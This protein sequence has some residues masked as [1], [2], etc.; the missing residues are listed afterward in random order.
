MSKQ[1]PEIA[2]Y[3]TTDGDRVKTGNPLTLVIADENERKKSVTDIAKALRGNVL[4]LQNGD[5]LIIV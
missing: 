4:Q 3:I 5:Y 1:S 2:V